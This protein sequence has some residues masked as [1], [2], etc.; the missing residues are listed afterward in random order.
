MFV[1][2]SPVTCTL[3]APVTVVKLQSQLDAPDVFAIAVLVGVPTKAALPPLG[4]L[5][6]PKNSHPAVSVPLSAV[7]ATTKILKT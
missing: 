7:C 3:N 4:L 1:E 2:A 5:I 6:N